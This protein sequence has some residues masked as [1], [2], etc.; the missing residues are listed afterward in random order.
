V[1]ECA[2]CGTRVAADARFCPECGRPL[3]GG[4]DA[5]GTAS[6]LSRA[7][8]RRATE[9]ML[10]AAVAALAVGI[11]LAV[12]GEW[13]WALVAV[14]AAAVAVLA[15]DRLSARS[16]PVAGLRARAAA[17]REAMAARSRE[18]LE[19]FRARRELAALE[20][21]QADLLRELGRAAYEGDEA[22]SAQARKALDEVVGRVA[23]KEAEIEALKQ[24]TEE[25]VGSAQASARPTERVAVAPDEAADGGPD[26]RRDPTSP[27]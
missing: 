13:A 24:A 8:L 4:E 15:L 20:G 10:A 6:L 21:E 9:P 12:R 17:A 25:R 11:V 27:A 1:R 3:A 7:R 14:L 16:R 2:T 5:A 23:A 26:A 18:Q 19:L 22:G